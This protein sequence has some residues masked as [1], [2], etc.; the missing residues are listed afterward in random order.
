[1]LLTKLRFDFNFS[2]VLALFGYLSRAHETEIFS[3]PCC[4]YPLYRMRGCLSNF[5]CCFP[6]KVVAF[7]SFENKIFGMV[8]T[9]KN[10]FVFVFVNMGV[11]MAVTISRRCTF[12]SQPKVAKVFKLVLNLLEIFEGFSFRL[13]MIFFLNYRFTIVPRVHW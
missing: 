11:P 7:R 12:K 5:S 2:V 13:L 6:N 8:L 9:T 4:N 3:R 1:M 10:R